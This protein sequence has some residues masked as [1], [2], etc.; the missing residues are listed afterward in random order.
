LIV[1]ILLCHARRPYRVDPALGRP[2]P[3][4]GY[5]AATLLGVVVG[6]AIG[7]RAQT[8]HWSFTAQTDACVKL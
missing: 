4:T 3:N 2:D 1:L 6:G 8:R 5:A 7:S